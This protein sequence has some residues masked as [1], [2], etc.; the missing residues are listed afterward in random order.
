M[1]TKL[2]VKNFIL[3][4]DITIDLGSGLNILTGETGAGKSVIV[5]ALDYILGRQISVNLAY[6]QDN[7]V[8]LTAYFNLEK[9][10]AESVG[11]IIESKLPSELSNL[12][13]RREISVKGRSAAYINDGRVNNRQIA[14][15]RPLLI[16]FHSQREQMKLFDENYQLNVLDVWAGLTGLRNEYTVCFEGLKSAIEKKKRLE[17]EEKRNTEKMLLYEYQIQEIESMELS[18]A[19][20]KRLNQELDLLSNSEEIMTLCSEIQHNFTEQDSSIIDV[21]SSYQKNMQ[22][23]APTD[24]QKIKNIISL[25]DEISHSLTDLTAELRELEE[26][27]ELD[28]EKMDSVE[29]RLSSILRIKN[30]YKMEIPQ[31]L[32]HLNM[33]KSAV[34]QWSSRKKDIEQLSEKISVLAEKTVSLAERLSIKRKKS[35]EP[36]ADTITADLKTLAI[37]N[38]IFSV[39]ITSIGK[40]YINNDFL[41]GL[42]DTGNDKIEFRFTANKGTK[43]EALKEVVS[44]GELSRL[45]LAIKKVLAGKIASPTLVLDEIDAGIGGR[46]AISTGDYIGKISSF[47]QVLCITHLPQ[48][49]TFGDKQFM[50]EKKADLNRPLIKVKEL[51]AS[52]RRD[53]IARMLSGTKSEIALKHADELLKKRLRENN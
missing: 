13:I 17:N 24:N 12:I 19:E 37:P 44:G 38:A 3:S 21:I 6:N 5:G 35:A 46:T 1:L 7:P 52:E 10:K 26:S 40:I 29:E 18:A 45:L 33:M 14:E 2:T 41:G 50:I 53:E 48:I 20:E 4:D 28:R 34:K 49:A 27:I 16:D 32:Q 25:F 30:K 22:R 23:L 47:H 8:C 43:P 9:D 31:L 11:R 42:N 51:S 39:D 36:F 15:I